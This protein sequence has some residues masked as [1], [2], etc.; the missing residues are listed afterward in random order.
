MRDTGTLTLREEYAL[1]VFENS[2]EKVQLEIREKNKQKIGCRKF[3]NDS[4]ISVVIGQHKI[5]PKLVI[6]R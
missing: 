4:I 5:T 3:R 1:T 6:L 2:S